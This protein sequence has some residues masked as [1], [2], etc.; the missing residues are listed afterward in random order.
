MLCYFGRNEDGEVESK[1]YIFRVS[2][3]EH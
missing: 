1:A 3:C 2:S